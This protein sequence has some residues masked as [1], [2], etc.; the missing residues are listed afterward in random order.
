MF[1]AG[2]RMRLKKVVVEVSYLCVG[3]PCRP[4]IES[5]RSSAIS[6]L[7]ILFSFMDILP[8]P[9]KNEFLN[10][11]VDIMFCIWGYLPQRFKDKFC[12]RWVEMQGQSFRFMLYTVWLIE[13]L[14]RKRILM[15]NAWETEMS[16]VLDD[17]LGVDVVDCTCA[18]EIDGVDE[19]S[20]LSKRIT[21]VVIDG[22]SDISRV[23]VVPK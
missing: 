18:L 6:K 5:L 3:T 22:H 17:W 8:D 15:S 13:K 23:L 20:A 4:C 7:S 19:S 14:E 12:S 1:Q 11:S 10:M 2:T 21:Y 16:R 9:C